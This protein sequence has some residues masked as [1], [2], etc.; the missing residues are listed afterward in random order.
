M[1]RDDE[2]LSVAGCASLDDLSASQRANRL[3]GC[4]HMPPLVRGGGRMPVTA[5][6]ELSKVDGFRS[7]QIAR[8]Y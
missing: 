4:T 8:V 7:C 3:I 6:D 2:A 1:S 5:G